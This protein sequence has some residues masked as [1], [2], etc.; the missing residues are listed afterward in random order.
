[1]RDH[2]SAERV[3]AQ[4]QLLLKRV[5]LNKPE[6]RPECR[7]L[8][9]VS[10]WRHQRE[11]SATCESILVISSNLALWPGLFLPLN[12]LS[13]AVAISAFVREG[14]KRSVHSSPGGSLRIPPTPHPTP[15]R[16]LRR[17]TARLT[18]ATSKE[19]SPGHTATSTASRANAQQS[20]TVHQG[21]DFLIS[22]GQETSTTRS[23][24]VAA[25]HQATS[26]ARG[27]STLSDEI[28]KKHIPTI[29]ECLQFRGP[30]DP[31][32]GDEYYRRVRDSAKEVLDA[33]YDTDNAPGLGGM[34]M[35]ARIQ[36]VG[37]PA[38]N[39]SSNSGWS[40]KIWGKGGSGGDNL[41]S[42]PTAGGP[43]GGYGGQGQYGYPSDPNQGG[44]NGP[45]SYGQQQPPYQPEYPSYG[46]PA[47]PG[48]PAPYGGQP[49]YG[50]PPPFN[51]QKFS[52]IGNPMY[53]D[54]RDEKGFFQG[55]KEKAASKFTKSD[56]RPVG[57]MNGAPPGST[58]PPD[59]WSFATNRGP[60]SGNYGPGVPAYNP[61]ETYR[62]SNYVGGGYQPGS[63]AYGSRNDSREIVSSQLREKSY[64]GDRK[65]GRVGGA[66]SD[67]PEVTPPPPLVSMSSGGRD[68]RNQSFSGSGNDGR[69]NRSMSRG[70][71]SEYGGYDA[72]QQQ[73]APV[74]PPAYTQQPVLT[75]QTSGAQSDG[76][77][78]RNLVTVLC[79]PGGMRAIPPKDKLDAFVKS[80]LTLDAEIVGP[81]LEDCLADAQWTVVSKALATIDTL[82]KAD[83]CEDFFD[84]F[85]E[86]FSEIESCAQS[87][88]AAI[89]DRAVKVLSA[90]GQS[91]GAAPAPSSSRSTSSASKARGSRP[92]SNYQQPQADLL[93][94]FSDPSPSDNGSLFSGL[95]TAAPSQQTPAPA[96]QSSA[97]NDVVDMFG[98]LSL[99][100]SVPVNAPAAEAPKPAAPAP[101]PSQTLILDPLL[102]PVPTPSPMMNTGFGG[103]GM[104]MMGY[105]APQQQMAQMAQMQQMQ[106]M[107]QFQ[108]MQQMQYM[109]MQQM[110]GV[111]GAT[112]TPDA[113]A[114]M[115]SQVIGAAMTPT[116][117]FGLWVHEEEGRPQQ[118]N[119]KK[120][121]NPIPHP[122]PKQPPK[123]KQKNKN[124]KSTPP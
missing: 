19:D 50:G 118:H 85:A 3:W 47:G 81:I 79:A 109:Q 77:Y 28:A 93:G 82:L 45:Q 106:Q 100:S 99:Q 43:I 65:K 90:L 18:G 103:M 67:A 5:S 35:S 78:E 105:N 53:Q 25:G 124:T 111:G 29:K 56:G 121:H 61:E 119:K 2:H 9:A 86:N 88:K 46:G 63:V 39:A 41:P 101:T 73:R 27:A 68:N 17:R 112:M 10:T 20:S 36:G 7:W 83:G 59:G 37:N 14:R 55:L 38:D 120:T 115:G 70:A 107:Q 87:D 114:R 34:G 42:V 52:G 76:S 116:G 22:R 32:K 26:V 12:S 24:Q 64:D 102:E 8:L 51:D 40:S 113:R 57:N 69:D 54:A 96:A 92:S 15:Y 4:N 91:T 122:K 49:S 71:S 60:T 21:A 117:R 58:N 33:I 98:G 80:A 108:Y 75:G 31:L 84:Y 23:S 104:N 13:L 30:P 94:D 89:R 110:Q 66:W 44:Y 11:S 62:P 72:Q 97:S 74:A 6:T 16:G 1:M 48:A 95:Q 123:Q